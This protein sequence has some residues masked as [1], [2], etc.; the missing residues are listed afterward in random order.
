M[1]NTEQT[2]KDYS[3]ENKLNKE[4]EDK[5]EIL[6][7]RRY[8]LNQNNECKISQKQIQADDLKIQVDFLHS[9]LL[10][11]ILHKEVKIICE[12]YSLLNIQECED[13]VDLG[14]IIMITY[15]RVAKKYKPDAGEFIN[16]FTRAFKNNVINEAKTKVKKLTNVDSLDEPI[17]DSDSHQT[18]IDTISSRDYEQQESENETIRNLFCEID[19]IYNERKSGQKNKAIAYTSMVMDYLLTMPEESLKRTITKYSFLQNQKKNILYFF[20][21]KE[22]VLTHIPQNVYASL[23]NV[24]NVVVCR[25]CSALVKR[26]KEEAVDK[27][28]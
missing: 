15:E 11:N 18:V 8:E 7:Q 19:R 22:T 6:F 2:K 26:L 16:Y 25:L 21:D 14:Y 24:D 5:I 17:K 9:K 3:L 27:D 4:L 23:C 20:Q 10:K 13:E 28:F 1:S 12:Q